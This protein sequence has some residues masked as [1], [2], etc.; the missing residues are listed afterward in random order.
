MNLNGKSFLITGGASLIGSHIATQLLDHGVERV[1]LF[2]NMSLGSEEA[3]RHLAG[4][5]KVEL[6]RGDILRMNQLM[7]AMKGVDG[8]FAVAG[9]LTLPLSADPW[10]GTEVNVRGHQTVLEACRWSN[11]K[12]VVFSS[13]AAVYGT[14]LGG[15][16]DETHPF[17]TAGL[18][19]AGTIYGAS[20]IIG[21]GLCRYYHQNYK[22]DYVALRYT[23][24]YGERQHFRGVNALYIIEAYDRIRAGKPPVLPGDGTEVHDY[25]YVGDVARANIMAMASDVTD[26]SFTIT[27]AVETNLNELTDI[28][29]RLTGS[30]LRPE[31]TNA[32]RKVAFTTTSEL[33][34]SREKAKKLLGWEP[35]VS[36]DEGVRRLIAWREEGAATARRAS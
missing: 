5:A 35:Q 4:N 1:V 20:K 36:I 17:N 8:V 14:P 3:V 22:L 19:A 28:I 25:V 11:V 21:E 6:V 16:I 32:P 29:L 24:V 10:L 2:D 13:S 31:Y 26:E 7:A 15:V 34:Y 33:K 27:T 12:K 30:K 18:G 9:I 23:T